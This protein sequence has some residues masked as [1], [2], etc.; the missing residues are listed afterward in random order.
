MPVTFDTFNAD[1]FNPAQN[2]I[3]ACTVLFAAAEAFIILV[4]LLLRLTDG[5]ARNPRPR[6]VLRQPQGFVGP[7]ANM[8]D[9]GLGGG[10]GLW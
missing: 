9:G 3:L 4:L 2:T 6:R 1:I 5:L 7:P 10:P 8:F